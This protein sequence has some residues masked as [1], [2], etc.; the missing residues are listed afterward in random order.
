MAVVFFDTT[1]GHIRKIQMRKQEV[2][3]KSLQRWNRYLDWQPHMRRVWQQT[4]V[5]WRSARENTFLWQM[6]YWVPATQQ[7]RFP[8]ASR[9]D[10]QVHCTRCRRNQVEDIHHCIWS[11]PRSSRVWRWFTTLIQSTSGAKDRVVKLQ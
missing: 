7:W 3:H 10:D 11:C 6:L 9:I 1:T 4:W 8:K 2:M 5:P